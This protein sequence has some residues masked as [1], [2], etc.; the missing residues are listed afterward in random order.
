M[1]NT[2][3]EFMEEFGKHK[4]KVDWYLH[5]PTPFADYTQL[6]GRDVLCSP[7]TVMSDPPVHVYLDFV[8][9][10]AEIHSTFVR[11]VMAASDHSLL[12]LKQAVEKFPVDKFP[13]SRAPEALELRHRLLEVLGIEDNITS[14]GGSSEEG[15][16]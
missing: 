16:F 12:G 4:D 15:A 3:D 11:V 9:L 13:M 6:R 8:D 1:I 5:A 10:D 7:L 2:V 14:E